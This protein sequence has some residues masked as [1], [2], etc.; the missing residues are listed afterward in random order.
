[1]GFQIEPNDD[2]PHGMDNEVDLPGTFIPA[3]LNGCRQIGLGYFL[4]P[5]APRGIPDIQNTESRCGKVLF[6]L[7][8]RGSG[9]GQAVEKDNK[10]RRQRISGDRAMNHGKNQQNK[11]NSHFSTE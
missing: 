10:F 1:V 7:P 4:D 3:L 2:A 9:P 5:Q 11:N 8:H 6:Q